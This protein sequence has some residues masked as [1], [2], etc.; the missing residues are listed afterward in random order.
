LAPRLAATRDI[1]HR[2]A[3]FLMGAT[4]GRDNGSRQREGTPKVGHRIR[5]ASQATS[6]LVGGGACDRDPYRHGKDRRS[7]TPARFDQARQEAMRRETT[8]KDGGRSESGM[9]PG[10]RAWRKGF[11]HR[12]GVG[13]R[14]CERRS[15]TQGWDAQCHSTTQVLLRML[16]IALRRPSHPWPAPRSCAETMPRVRAG[17]IRSSPSRRR[18]RPGSC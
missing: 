2:I 8:A 14:G 7:G 13:G 6:V 1:A 9:R 15:M 12:V 3:R 18:T 16:A 5:E 10:W 11:R 17:C 4:C